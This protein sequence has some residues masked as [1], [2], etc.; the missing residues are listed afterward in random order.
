[1]KIVMVCLGNICRS[2]LAD[3]LLRKK[4]A[5]AGLDIEVDSAGTAA[6]HVGNPPDGRMIATAKSK[7]CPI[8]EL[9]AR[10]FVV[11]DYDR[12][13]RIFVMD[14]SN[15]RNVLSLARNS[16]DEAKVEMILNLSHPNQ[17]LEVPD[18][19]YGGDQGFLDV[20]TMLDDATDVLMNQLTEQNN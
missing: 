6:F 13:D 12:F 9:R 14:E 5:E 16:E 7:D 4:V 2:P 17:D 18:P 8:D 19:Y 11:Q 1:M 15:R 20:Y 3:G 10:Q